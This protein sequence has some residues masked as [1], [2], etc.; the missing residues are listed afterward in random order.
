ME[1]EDWDL[2]DPLNPSLRSEDSWAWKLCAGEVKGKGTACLC[3]L[4]LIPCSL[5]ITGGRGAQVHLGLLT[6]KEEESGSMLGEAARLAV[7]SWG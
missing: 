1:R 2:P 4:W 7:T 6:R 3:W 5:G